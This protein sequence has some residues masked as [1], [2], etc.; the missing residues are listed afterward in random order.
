MCFGTQRDEPI[1]V[2]LVEDQEPARR[3]LR[4]LLSACPDLDV[5]ADA[6]DGGEAVC[7]AGSYRP[8]VVLIDL[9]IPGMGSVRTIRM[10]KD[11]W[12]KT[13]VLALTNSAGKLEADAR[14][15]GADAFL[16][17]SVS[18]RGLTAAIRDLAT[19]SSF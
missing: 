16:R 4:R 1:G 5:V 12:P 15:A 8:D 17:K 11:H 7:L 18:P 14:A 10:I 3:G 2:L 9:L 19:R 6:A 13:A